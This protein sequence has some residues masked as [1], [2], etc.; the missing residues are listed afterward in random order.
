MKP[1]IARFTPLLV[2]LALLAGCSTP[3]TVSVN[4][5]AVYDPDGRLARNVVVD[6]DLQGCINLAMR[7]QRVNSAADLTVLSCANSQIA[8]LDNIEALRNLR[9][10]DVAGNAITNITPLEGLRELSSLN[11]ADNQIIDVSPLL[12]VRSLV[13]VSLLGNNAIPCIQ[14]QQLRARLG[15][16]LT[17]PSSCTN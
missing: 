16:N 13:T 4:D 14:L 2:S 9:F 17:A 7:Q 10:L 3:F 5:Q 1:R 12:N 6:A 11:L 15:D 8:V